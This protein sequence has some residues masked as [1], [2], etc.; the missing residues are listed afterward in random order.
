MEEL[1]PLARGALVSMHRELSAVVKPST[2]KLPVN[3]REVSVQR[4][5]KTGVLYAWLSE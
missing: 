1:A 5:G 3:A 2:A 4:S